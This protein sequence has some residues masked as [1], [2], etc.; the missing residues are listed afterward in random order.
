MVERMRDVYLQRWARSTVEHYEF[1]NVGFAEDRGLRVL[2]RAS[3]TTS[4]STG[5]S[6]STA[7]SPT[8]RCG[9][10]PEQVTEKLLD[11]V[12]RCDAGALVVP[13]VVRRHVH[14]GVARVLRPL[15]QRGAP[16]AR[17]AR[18]RR[19]PRR[20]LRRDRPRGADRRVANRD[21]RG[22]SAARHSSDSP[23]QFALYV[24]RTGDSTLRCVIRCASRGCGWTRAMGVSRLSLARRA[25]TLA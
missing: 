21:R 19:R 13:L 2:Q 6:S 25:P 22:S 20:H 17:E 18:R 7:S 12:E 11:Y 16:R 3:P 1:D 10:S 15:R 8:C 9:A 24:A 5:W 23:S 4:P 14:R